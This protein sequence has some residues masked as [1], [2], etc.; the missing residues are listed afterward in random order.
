M[1]DNSFAGGNQSSIGIPAGASLGA[2]VSPMVSDEGSARRFDA[3]AL[4]EF[5]LLWWGGV[6]VFLAMQTQQVAR[7]WLAYELTGTNTALGGVLIG[8]GVA[9]L[10]AI[11]TGGVLADRFDKRSILM[12]CQTINTVTA[13]TIGVA[14]ET[15]VIAYW[16]IVAASVVGGSTISILAPAR[17]AMTADL[18]SV[19]RLTNAIMLGSMSSQATRIVGP[20]IA[21]TMIGIAVLGTEGVYYLSAVL[22][23]VAVLLTIRLPSSRPARRVDRSPW[24]DLRA[25][26]GYTRDRPELVRPLVLS[27][28]VV[29]FGFAHQA[30]LPT[31]VDE[32]FG[33]GAQGLGLMTTASAVGA[34]VMS[35]G[36]ANTQR[37]DLDRRQLGAAY[38]FG[39]CL[40]AFALAPSFGL[41]LAAMFFVGCAMAA[42]QTLNSSLVLSTADVAFHGRVQSL[43][44][45]SYS[46]FG[47]AALPAGVLADRLGLRETMVGMGLAVVAA[48]VHGHLWRLRATRGA[49]TVS[50]DAF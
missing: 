5:R 22:S 33:Q 27:V 47:L 41:A 19:D 43:I 7:S 15:G 44:M 18:V 29:M 13:V 35:I 39:G 16:M 20:A 14:I 10:V 38:S 36:L 34:V 46:A 42:F 9:G 17:I 26:V 32:F 37:E 24:D 45:L 21:G 11:P 12:A 50:A 8:F 1:S 3:L 6:F 30:F 31:V 2:R 4:P 23:A 28:L 49:S 25:G 48:A 40:V